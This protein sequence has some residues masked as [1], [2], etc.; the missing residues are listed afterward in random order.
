MGKFTKGE[1][2][3]ILESNRIVRKA[4]VLNQIGNMYTIQFASSNGIIRLKESRLFKTEDEALES[5]YINSYKIDAKETGVSY[6][7]LTCLKEGEL[8]E[9]RIDKDDTY[10]V[11]SFLI[12]S[13]SKS[14]PKSIAY[15]YQRGNGN[16][17]LFKPTT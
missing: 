15:F 11:S 5:R 4:Y 6:G 17:I 16:I 12:S 13:I 1:I 2:C 14:Q 8:I 3:Y 9:I 10:L 7:I